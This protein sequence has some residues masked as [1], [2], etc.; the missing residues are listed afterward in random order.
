MKQWGVHQWENC[1][2]V[3]NWISL[4]SLLAIASINELTC[5]SIDFVLDFTK[6]DLDVEFFMYINLGI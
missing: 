1:S 6:S 4:K 2:R 5:I 3:V